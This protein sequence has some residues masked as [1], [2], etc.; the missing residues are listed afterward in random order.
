MMSLIKH[1]EC[2][3]PLVDGLPS[4]N[5]RLAPPPPAP[6]SVAIRCFVRPASAPNARLNQAPEPEK[7]AVLG[8]LLWIKE[9]TSHYMYKEVQENVT[10]CECEVMR[11]K[12]SRWVF[13]AES[14]YVYLFINPFLSENFSGKCVILFNT[15]L[16]KCSKN[17]Y[18]YMSLLYELHL[19]F[20]FHS[21]LSPLI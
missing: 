3:N 15:H 20:P 17:E 8:I 21:R 19:C 11:S 18:V 14:R 2:C 7:E 10:T 12:C 4:Y 9:N 13:F 1:S 16:N 6:A 5:S